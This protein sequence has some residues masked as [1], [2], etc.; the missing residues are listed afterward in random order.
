M[1]GFFD[2]VRVSIVW[3]VPRMAPG[4]LNLVELH[5]C[6]ARA[7]LVHYDDLMLCGEGNSVDRF[8]SGA[9]WRTGSTPVNASGGLQS[10]G[11]PSAATRIANVWKVCHYLRGEPGPR[12]NEGAKAGLNCPGFSGDSVSWAPLPWRTPLL[13]D[14]TLPRTLPAGHSRSARRGVDC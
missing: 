8:K 10:K 1:A 4:D 5:D 2:H 14:R 3:T 12:Q 11:H 9:T 7:E 6:F 13:A